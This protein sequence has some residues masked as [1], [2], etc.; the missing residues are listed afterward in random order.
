M[1]AVG[2]PVSSTP[3]LLEIADACHDYR[4][5]DISLKNYTNIILSNGSRSGLGSSTNPIKFSQFASQK[6][7]YNG[8]FS[9][10]YDF[11]W[12][13][14]GNGFSLIHSRNGEYHILSIQNNSGA[15]TAVT[16]SS[17]TIHRQVY[18]PGG[19]QAYFSIPNG[20][21]AAISDDGNIIMINT[22][23]NGNY[24]GFSWSNARMW[25]IGYWNGSSYSSVTNYSYPAIAYYSWSYASTGFSHFGQFVTKNNNNNVHCSPVTYS[26][27]YPTRYAYIY[28]VTYNGTTTQ[29]TISGF[30]FSNLSTTQPLRCYLSDNLKMVFIA[31]ERN[32]A[33]GGTENISVWQVNAQGNGWDLQKDFG[34]TTYGHGS[35][36]TNIS[37]VSLAK[38]V[39]YRDGT[40][41]T[42]YSTSKSDMRNGVYPSGPPSALSADGTY[43]VN[44]YNRDYPSYGNWYWYLTL[45]CKAYKSSR[46]D[47]EWRYGG[48]IIPWLNDGMNGDYVGYNYNFYERGYSMV[49]DTIWLTYGGN[50]GGGALK[51]GYTNRNIALMKITWTNK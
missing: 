42:Q 34:N 48:Y 5:S 2:I 20:T 17:G 25:W 35:C 47:H 39:W 26:Y 9:K 49:G 45:L 40:T 31:D 4:T 10:V 46:S 29:P 41:W 3:S 27:T 6:V 11:G 12:M 18:L 32:S 37:K 19:S 23:L 16:N 14:S 7:I 22:T 15:W 43:M 38:D 1:A 33:P 36:D 24:G 8:T 44:P 13:G 51:P 21:S 28:T 30:P 50:G